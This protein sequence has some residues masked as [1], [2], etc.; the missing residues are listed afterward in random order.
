M[1][2]TPGSKRHNLHAVELSQR[3]GKPC[4]NCVDPSSPAMIT[5]FWAIRPCEPTGWL[6]MLLVKAVD[7]ETNPGPTTTR[8][9]VW[10][11]DI[12]H[13]QMQVRKKIS[14]RCNRIE[15]FITHLYDYHIITLTYHTIYHTHS[16]C[17]H[18]IRLIFHTCYH[19]LFT[20][21]F[22]T[23]L[24]YYYIIKLINLSYYLPH[25]CSVTTLSE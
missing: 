12:C 14:I 2:T 7:V 4:I 8:K 17:Y 13:I 18:T 22:N 1:M 23:H 3:S 19:T 10:I 5:V 20:T 6:A 9:Q 15:L 16:Y 24:Y 11:Y 25:T 21:L